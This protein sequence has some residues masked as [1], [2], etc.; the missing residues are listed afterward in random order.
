MDKATW[1]IW[2]WHIKDSHNNQFG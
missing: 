1:F 2:L